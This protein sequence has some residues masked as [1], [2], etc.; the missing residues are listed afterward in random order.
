MAH[1]G[2]HYCNEYCSE[3]RNFF[4]N[5]RKSLKSMGCNHSKPIVHP[6]NPHLESQ[7]NNEDE[8]D[9]TG[10]EEDFLEEEYNGEEQEEIL[11]FFNQNPNSG[12]GIAAFPSFFS[13]ESK[14]AIFEYQFCEHVGKGARSDVFRVINTENGNEYAAKVYDKNYLFRKC[15]GDNEPPI[16]KFL[17]EVNIMDLLHSPFCLSLIEL[18]DDEQTNS[19]IMIFPFAR[20]G[21]LSP[22]SWKAKPLPENEI[23]SIFHQVAQG[24][25]YL[26][27]LNIIH[28]D[29]KPENVLRIDENTA[30][31]SDFSASISISNDPDQYL[32]DTDGTPAF[33]SPE[34][35]SGKAYKGKPADVWALGMT[36]YVL[37]VGKLFFVKDDNYFI[38]SQFFKIA[39]SIINDEIT[40][41]NTLSPELVNLLRHMLDKNPQ[42]R[43]T[44]DQVCEDP[45]LSSQ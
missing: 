42:T 34:E 20:C 1:I 24:V 10:E 44:I 32:E 11:T 37:A 33:Y 43:Y 39:D 12:H 3:L 4:E 31:L 8:Y 38:C 35:C 41:P 29:I 30:V 9:T 21:A 36:M 23:R 18:L 14:P 19:M 15:I 16:Q 27:S 6:N 13:S 5:F 25:Q 26:H 17:R 22:S 28:R 7:K 2:S 40:Y 45:W